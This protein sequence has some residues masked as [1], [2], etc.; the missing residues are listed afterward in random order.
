[1]TIIIK[2]YAKS[3]FIHTHLV[4]CQQIIYPK[5]NLLEQATIPVK[6]LFTDKTTGFDHAIFFFYFSFFLFFVF[7]NAKN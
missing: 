4:C 3:D 6:Q 5:V 1:M 7:H 2:C